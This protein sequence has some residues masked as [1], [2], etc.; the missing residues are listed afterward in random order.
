MEPKNLESQAADRQ[1]WR[2][3]TKAGLALFDEGRIRWLNERRERRHRETTTTGPDF[4]CPECGK[5]CRS[6]IG[7]ISHTRAHQRRREAEQA[8]IVGADGPP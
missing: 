3:I 1:E 5:C 7:L 8:V 6:R 2:E 4:P